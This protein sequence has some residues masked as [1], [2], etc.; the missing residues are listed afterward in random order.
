MMSLK[1]FILFSI[2]IL[3]V[4]VSAQAATTNC[5]GAPA[6]NNFTV[7]STGGT[8][9]QHHDTSHDGN[10][11]LTSFNNEAMGTSS[12]T[13]GANPSTVN[14][15]LFRGKSY[16]AN[17]SCPGTNIGQLQIGVGLP[18]NSPYNIPQNTSYF[19]DVF[20]S[21]YS[22]LAITGYPGAP[23]CGGVTNN[24]PVTI[25]NAPCGSYLVVTTNGNCTKFA[26][27]SEGDRVPNCG[28]NGN[29]DVTSDYCYSNGLP[30]T[31]A[32]IGRFKP[33]TLITFQTQ[34]NGTSILS[35]TVVGIIPQ[36][37]S[38]NFW[39]V[40]CT[41]TLKTVADFAIWRNGDEAIESV[42]IDGCN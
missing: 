23:E 30:T 40:D 29:G 4:S 34:P 7:T 22:T 27:N 39:R 33:N 17:G 3:S 25:F 21:T 15:G 28:K 14:S 2:L 38:G 24:T 10:G 9:F 19:P 18:T 8:L 5:G 35:G 13:G 41:V 12:A 42:V 16:C 20:N 31:C 37:N 36:A 11:N 26:T 1:N 6:C 32:F